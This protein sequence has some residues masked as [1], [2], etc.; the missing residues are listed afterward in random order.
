MKGHYKNVENKRKSGQV[1]S[2]MLPLQLKT[3]GP[4]FWRFYTEDREDLECR[5]DVAD[6]GSE[7]PEDSWYNQQTVAQNGV[8]VPPA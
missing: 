2:W 1:W 5:P 3:A 6:T 4:Q 7:P 8:Q